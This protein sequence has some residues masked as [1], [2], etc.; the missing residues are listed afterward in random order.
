MC[1]I[2]SYLKICMQSAYPG[3]GMLKSIISAPK[4]YCHNTSVEKCCLSSI[5]IKI[6]ALQN[7]KIVFCCIE[8]HTSGNE[9]DSYFAMPGPI[10]VTVERKAVLRRTLG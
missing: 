8:D 1:I 3:T 7:F 9:M 6:S 2:V 5:C 10:Y 4:Y